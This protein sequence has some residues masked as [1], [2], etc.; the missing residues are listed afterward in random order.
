MAYTDPRDRK[1]PDAPRKDW[2]GDF[3]EDLYREPQEGRPPE[4][5]RGTQPGEPGT[6]REQPDRSRER[7]PNPS[8][9]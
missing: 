2:E 3:E 5:E 1:K 9:R 6:P 4:R 8:A 7:S